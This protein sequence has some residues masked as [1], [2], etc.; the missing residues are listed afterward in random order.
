MAAQLDALLTG[1]SPEV[2]DLFTAA[3]ALIHSLVPTAVEDFDPKAK[4]LGYTFKPGTYHGLVLAI[5]PAKKHVTL[6][7]SHGVELE[8]VD[9]AGLLEGTGKRARHIKVKTQ[10]GLADPNVHKL[11]Q[12]AA[13][14]T[15]LRMGSGL[16]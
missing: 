8:L 11:I 2:R 4:L 15:A 9:E 6:I 12:A 3:H 14:I 13:A 16:N 7:F 1:Y 10:A 5:M